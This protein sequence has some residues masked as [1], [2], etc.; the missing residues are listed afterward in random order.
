MEEATMP[1]PSLS[2]SDT[3]QKS[4]Q[5]PE[6]GCETPD[7]VSKE[8]L[9]SRFILEA[10]DPFRPRWVDFTNPVERSCAHIV[11]MLG[12]AGHYIH[13]NGGGR[14]GRQPVLCALLKQGGQM[15][16][17]ELMCKFDL[18]AGSLSEVLTKLE[19][20][21]LIERTRDEQD[22]RQ[23]IVKLTELG[24]KEAQEEQV[25]REKFRRE[26]F[27]CISDEERTQL[28]DILSRI[29]VHWRSLND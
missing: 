23:L 12:A 2:C 27:T 7:D 29:N 16:Q 3:S 14:S 22:R 26:A 1:E 28:E 20:S 25:R 6:M 15:P 18:K 13:V 9:S 10:D 5:A 8:A 17:R 11:D 24:N 21:G 4:E 19:K